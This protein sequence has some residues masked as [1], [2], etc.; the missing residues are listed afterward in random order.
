MDDKNGAT[1]QQDDPLPA[2]TTNRR[3][4]NTMPTVYPDVDFVN[5]TLP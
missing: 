2:A 4:D 3:T 1:N 5:R